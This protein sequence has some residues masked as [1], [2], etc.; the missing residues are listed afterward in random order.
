MNILHVKK[1]F[2]LINDIFYSI[3][4]EAKFACSLLGKAFEKQLKINKCNKLKL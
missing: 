3:I 1:H 2:L 4:E